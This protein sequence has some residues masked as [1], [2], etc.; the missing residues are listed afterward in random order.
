MLKLSTSFA[1]ILI[2]TVYRGLQAQ[3][4]PNAPERIQDGVQQLTPSTPFPSSVD[5]RP[6]IRI[7]LVRHGCYGSCAQY[8]VTVFGNGRVLYEGTEFVR[9]KGRAR[10]IIADKAVD[11]LIRRVNDIHFFSFQAE[12]S[13]RCVTDGPTASITVS[14]PVREKQIDDECVES[15]ELEELEKAVDDVVDIQQWVF[16]NAT[17]LQRQLDRGW[18]IATQGQEYAQQAI[19]W[20]DPQVI[21]VLVRNGVPVETQDQDGE[22]LLMQAVLRNRYR[23]AKTLLELGANPK[24]RHSDGWGP[25]QNAANRSV[26]MCKLFLS[27]SAGI[28]DQDGMGETMLMNAAGSPD[29]LEIVKFLVSSGAALNLRNQNGE[30]A[31]GIA[32]RMRQQF[33]QSIDF[34]L[35]PDYPAFLGD[36]ETA[37]AG[38]VATMHQYEAV[39]EYLRQHGGTE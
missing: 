17:E 37:R 9:V 22:T 26:E 38:H 33:Q 24:T 7:R 3:D 6:K 39:I 8:S 32:S 5:L 35:R 25:S 34:T 1:V 2:L 13:Q 16:I 31:I 28:N 23:S 27:H 12:K 21:R 15:K 20:D 4:V 29:N 30:T 19:E 14:E 11:D 10:A 18:D 36:P